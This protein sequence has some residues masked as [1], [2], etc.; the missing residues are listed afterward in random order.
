MMRRRRSGD[1]AEKGLVPL[2]AVES[3]SGEAEFECGCALWRL[4]ELCSFWQF[5]VSCFKV[6]SKKR[7]NKIK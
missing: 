1:A 6:T 4:S 2:P 3:W 7:K 5:S